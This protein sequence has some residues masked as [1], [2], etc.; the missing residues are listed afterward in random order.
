MSENNIDIDKKLSTVI[1]VTDDKSHLHPCQEDCRECVSKCCTFVCPA[2]VY[3]WSEERQELL[4][5]YENC[6]E[7]GACKI[8]CEKKSLGWEYPKGTKGV[9][10]KQG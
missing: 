1:Y 5:N 8:V 9:V 7:C 3:E 6:L 2:K 4:V 10:F